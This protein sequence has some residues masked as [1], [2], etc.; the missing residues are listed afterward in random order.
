MRFRGFGYHVLSVLLF[1][2]LILA[3]WSAALTITFSKPAKLES[4]LN[5]SKLYDHFVAT[6]LEQS[7]KSVQANQSP[8]NS[9]LDINDPAVQDAAK[10]AITPD[11]LQKSVNTFL[12]ANYTWLEGKTAKPDF[13]IDLTGVK[14]ALAA[15]L[16]A[17]AQKRAIG[18]PKCINLVQAAQQTD[19]LTATC[20][21]PSITPTAAA[22]AV[23]QQV[24]DSQDFLAN[25][26]ITAQTFSPN[27]Q[28]TNQQSQPY[29]QRASFL[30]AAYRFATS[31]PWLTTLLALLCAA[32][33]ILLAA[34]R[35]KGFRRVAT[36]LMSTGVIILFLIFIS[37]TIIHRIETKFFTNDK[38]GQLQQSLV[39]FAH[40]AQNALANIDIWFGV[41]FIVIGFAIYIALHF[42][43]PTASNPE[44]TAAPDEPPTDKPEQP[45]TPQSK[46]PT[47]VQL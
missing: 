8:N 18:L 47:L 23:E 37:N 35:R 33:V 44:T 22:K 11:V 38:V 30:P 25:P 4:W 6:A 41:S 1:V 28:Q 7:Q 16:G 17:Y 31:L 40:R 24:A 3:A 34:P 42:T 9:G 36:L 20:L 32:G 14:A 10:A 26:V 21:P 2:F 12:D 15:N 45:Q 46:R 13:S 27:G 39:D 43:K 29:Y 5:Q 19:F